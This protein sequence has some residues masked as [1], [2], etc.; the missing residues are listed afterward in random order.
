VLALTCSPLPKWLCFSL[1]CPR[2]CRRVC[3]HLPM[4]ISSMPESVPVSAYLCLCWRLCSPPL[5]CPVCAEPV[6][7]ADKAQEPSLVEVHVLS[8]HANRCVRQWSSLLIQTGARGNGGSCSSKQVH[9][10]M[11]VTALPDRCTQQW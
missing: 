9:V 11:V 6:T 5:S 1:S 3:L 8:V 10:A 2:L 7:G 4:Y